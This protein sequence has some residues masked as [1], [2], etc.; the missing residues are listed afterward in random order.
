MSMDIEE[1]SER[2]NVQ[3]DDI[4]RPMNDE[5]YAEWLERSSTPLP[6]E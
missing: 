3:I 6:G 4:I 1:P 5:E 2:P